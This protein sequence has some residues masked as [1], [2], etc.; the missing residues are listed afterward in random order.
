MKIEPLFNSLFTV[1]SPPRL[2]TSFLTMASPSPTPS[3]MLCEE[4][5][6]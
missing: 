6:V 2:N 1:I 5:T 3:F 4:L